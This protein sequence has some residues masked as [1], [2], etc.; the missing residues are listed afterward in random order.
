MNDNLN[1]QIVALKDEI[2]MYKKVT[3]KAKQP[4]S[5]LSKNLQENESEILMLK[6]E[7]E[8]KDITI[9]RLKKE[10]E[11]FEDKVIHLENDLKRICNNREKLDNLE[12]VISSYIQNENNYTNAASI[13]NMYYYNNSTNYS[14]IMQSPEK[15]ND[16]MIIII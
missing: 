12:N 1:K 7:N 2:E 6:S 9:A 13:P 5:Y 15:D 11:V 8:K 3:E 4:Y 16:I 14:I 10:N